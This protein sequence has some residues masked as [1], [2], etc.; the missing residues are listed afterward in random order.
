[1]TIGFCQNCGHAL[2]EGSHFCGECGAG[3]ESP[4]APPPPAPSISAAPAAPLP[5]P[6]PAAHRKRPAWLVPVVA[7]CVAVVAIV[8]AVVVMTRDDD[9]STSAG[10]GEIFLEEATSNGRDP[11]TPS[12]DTNTAPPPV[13]L[14]PVAVTAST[15]TLAPTTL[16]PTTTSVGAT[17]TAAGTTTTIAITT[18]G[19]STTTLPGLPVR[20]VNGAAPGLYGGT[21]DNAAC[22]PEQM[23]SFLMASP[24][25]AMAWAGVQGIGPADI[26]TYIRSLTPVVLR[27]DTR[28]TNHGFANGVATSNPSILQ[29][30]TAVLVDQFGIP[31]ARCSCGNPLTPPIPITSSPTYVGDPWPGFDPSAVVVVTNVT[32][33]VVNNFVVVDLNGGY[34][35]RRPPKATPTGVVTDGPIYIDSLCD[36]FPQAAEC[37]PP[38]TT[39][40]TT[41]LPASS[42]TLAEPVLGTGDIQF[43]LRWSSTADLDLAVIDPNGE[44][45]YYGSR[46]SSSGGQLDVDSNALC[47][48]AVANPVE[49]VFW[50]TGQSIDGTY[51]VA[52]SYFNEC[53]EATGPQ[54]FR[55]S[56]LVNGVPVTLTPAQ[57]SLRQQVG[58][59]LAAQGDRKVYT[60]TKTPNPPATTVAPTTTATPSTQTSAAPTS[61]P[62]TENVP[63]S[64]IAPVGSPPPTVEPGEPIDLATYCAEMYPP[65]EIGP[66]NPWYTLCMHDPTVS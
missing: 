41:T 17:T 48:A 53:G 47:S 4:S 32:N 46:T 39:T 13:I 15:T 11:F 66:E 25:K 29:R 58:D 62:P 35:G 14:E 12:V 44:E 60:V 10:P 64:S 37:L 50:P 30:G 65:P 56:A 5:P 36:L 3:V 43:T 9:T 49:N 7:A 16:A 24:D 63:A 31:R 20:T 54:Q 23:I 27:A 45:I 59:Q 19:V 33:V 51:T 52:V 28:V 40:T 6:A 38:T 34:F 26:P 2:V 42:S 1:M 18:T 21:Q 8:A 61:R 55:L 57:A 22:D